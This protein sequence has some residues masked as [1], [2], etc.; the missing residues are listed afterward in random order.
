MTFNCYQML[1]LARTNGSTIHNVSR[2]LKDLEEAEWNL[3]TARR[4]KNLEAATEAA[5]II[6]SAVWA[7]HDRTGVHR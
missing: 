6:E 5:R 3:V 7:I 2:W 1:V 4:Q